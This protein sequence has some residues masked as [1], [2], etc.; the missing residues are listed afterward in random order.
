MPRNIS[1]SLTTDQVKRRTKTVTRRIG[2]R[3]L[4]NGQILNACVKC[5]G[6]RAGEK[7]VRLAQ[8]RVVSVST[9]PLNFILNRGRTECAREG[10]P[11][12]SPQEFV[13]MFASHMKC[14]EDTE[15]TRIAFEYVD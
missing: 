13:A 8:I 5:M 4:R 2:W 9:E 11:D 15:V 1:F 3:K 7:I 10:F 6:L 14:Q 12:L